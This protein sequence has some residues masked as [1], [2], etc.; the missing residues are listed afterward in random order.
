MSLVTRISKQLHNQA[1]SSTD[2]S[3]L[4]L[5]HKHTAAI[6]QKGTMNVLAVGRNYKDCVLRGF[7]KGKQKNSKRRSNFQERRSQSNCS[8]RMCCYKQLPIFGWKKNWSFKAMYASNS[9]SK[10]YRRI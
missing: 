10:Q 8:R 5:R 1:M 7:S 3:H 6:F 9:S 2:Q 4:D